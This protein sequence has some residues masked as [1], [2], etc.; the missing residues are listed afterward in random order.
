MEIGCSHGDLLSAF[1][2]D[3]CV[4]AS[5]LDYSEVNVAFAQR[6]GLKAKVGDLCAQ[7]YPDGSF[8]AAMCVLGLM[9]PADPQRAIEQMHRVLRPGG[10]AAVAVWGRRER[11]GWASIFPIRRLT[12]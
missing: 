3:P 4:E 12:G 9:Y 6:H 2:N 7:K 1:R 11:C 8:D 5:G 10:R